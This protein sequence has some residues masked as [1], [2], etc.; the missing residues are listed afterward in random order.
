LPQLYGHESLIELLREDQCRTGRERPGPTG[1]FWSA[2]RVDTY[3]FRQVFLIEGVVVRGFVYFGD[4][5][6]GLEGRL[7]RCRENENRNSLI[8]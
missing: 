6:A 7:E 8:S 4:L 5:E 1:P 3:D 2:R